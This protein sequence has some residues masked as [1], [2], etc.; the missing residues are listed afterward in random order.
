MIIGKTVIAKLRGAGDR[1]MRR[2]GNLELMISPAHP[3]TITRIV[4][5]KAKSRL[6]R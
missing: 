5:E 4:G 2:I 1:L 3:K 6:T